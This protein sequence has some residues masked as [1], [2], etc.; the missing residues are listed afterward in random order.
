MIFVIMPTKLVC[1]TNDTID[2]VYD[3]YS[4]PTGGKPTAWAQYTQIGSQEMGGQW[5][6]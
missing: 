4:D 2:S 6:E 1:L 5:Q 3:L